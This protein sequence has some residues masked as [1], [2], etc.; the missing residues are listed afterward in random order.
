MD[1]RQS[2]S[3]P[4][5]SATL[6]A[7]MTDNPTFLSSDSYERLLSGLKQRIKAANVRAAVSVNA[8]LIFLLTI[9]IQ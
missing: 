8:E 2:T 4:I 5:S 3:E 9:R 7:I 6:D 1:E